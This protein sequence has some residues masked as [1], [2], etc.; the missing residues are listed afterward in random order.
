MLVFKAKLVLA[1]VPVESK[2]YDFTD[3]K[4]GKQVAGTSIKA[5]VTCVGT[6]DRVAVITVKGK[7]VDE[8]NA[9]LNSLK[10]KVGS[11]AE[12]PI[13]ATVTGGVQQLRV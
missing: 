5:V 11:P 2:P 13:A 4:T 10:L 9:K 7:T 12:I 8:A 1:I 3:E 6:D